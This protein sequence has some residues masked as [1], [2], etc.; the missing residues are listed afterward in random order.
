VAEDGAEPG[1]SDTATPQAAEAR[2]QAAEARAQAAEERAQAA[3]ARTAEL[4]AQVQQLAAG[5]DADQ[6]RVAAL[7]DELARERAR[8]EEANPEVRQEAL[9]GAVGSL[10]AANQAL[11]S[12]SGDVQESIERAQAL[13]GEAGR[14]ASVGGS[15][16]EAAFAAEAQR[17][18]AASREALDRGDLFQAR[19]AAAAATRAAQQARG[20]AAQD[21]AGAAAGAG[22]S[23][24]Q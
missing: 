6:Q 12:G 24:G 8:R 15:A 7:E 10:D 21:A 19:V 3:E 11:L 20:L 9:G 13:A 18:I 23:T 4:E 1:A 2:V 22:G 14:R 5:L 16:E 17:W